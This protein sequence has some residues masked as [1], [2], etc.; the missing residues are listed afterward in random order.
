M[1]KNFISILLVCLLV[2][3][4]IPL[5]VLAD[6]YITSNQTGEDGR[7]AQPTAT[8]GPTLAPNPSVIPSLV[9]GPS[10]NPSEIP[11]VPT[12]N[13]KPPYEF[14]GPDENGLW[15]S[16]Y[17]SY[18]E[19][20]IF[21]INEAFQNTAAMPSTPYFDEWPSTQIEPW[22]LGQINQD[23]LK[24]CVDYFNLMRR[25]AGLNPV[26]L[27]DEANNKAQIVAWMMCHNQSL[28]HF[29]ACL[30]GVP[31]EW[32]S[33][34]YTAAQKSNLAH[35]S[36]IYGYISGQID[37]YM[38]DWQ[39]ANV[40]VVG[41]RQMV[42]NPRLV[43]TG[44]G[45]AGLYHANYIGHLS[46]GA[47][48]EDYDFIAWPSS[49]N[50]PN[51]TNAFELKSPWSVSFS[52][53]AIDNPSNDFITIT[54]EHN[55]VLIDELVLNYD[56]SYPANVNSPT[57]FITLESN[58]ANTYCFI[59]RPDLTNINVLEGVYTIHI[60]GLKVIRSH[61]DLDITYE[62]NFFSL[63]DD[64]NIPKIF[65]GDANC[66]GIVD[67]TDAL[68]VLRYVTGLIQLEGQGLINA[69]YNQ[70]GVVNA[71]DSLAILRKSL[72]II[73]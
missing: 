63:S 61:E 38:S 64:I 60:E 41:H 14:N 34:A 17:A 54:V 46:I 9:P 11:V 15:H 62:V 1:K 56:P 69:D 12:V 71:S 53:F 18:P 22:V 3:S 47:Q 50:F 20:S 45:S 27:N 2:L 48:L 57:R 44:F 43:D 8:P 66:D 25:L 59:F 16:G 24:N 68:M 10:I 51:N 39:S 13:P 7:G 36:S 42:L 28:T 32:C 21:D 58:T 31:N 5:Y 33:I 29:P 30:I 67:G 19:L 73:E 65:R 23:N 49:G 4:I 26:P 6:N 55:G 35:T 37:G 70:D 72:G 52:K 40:A